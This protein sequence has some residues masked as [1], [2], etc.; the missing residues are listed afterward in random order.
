MEFRFCPF[1]AKLL[2]EKRQG[3]HKRLYC[4]ACRY[5]HYRNPTVGVAV[6]LVENNELLL[7]KRVGSY[8]DTWCIP[9]GHLEYNEDVRSAAQREFKEETGL[10]VAIGPVFAVHSNFHDLEKQTVGIWFWGKWTGGQLQAGSDAADVRFFAL[11]EL[12][13]A[14][15]FPT[16]LLVCDKLKRCQASDDLPGWL[17]S[18][19]ARD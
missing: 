2:Q 13:P 3:R 10:D 18:S 8:E 5:T 11:V 14:M 16:D 1:C 6:V 9:C 19:L 4:H 12:P 15:A 17:E 7:V